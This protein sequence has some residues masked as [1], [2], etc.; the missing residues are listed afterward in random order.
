M[1]ASLTSTS[2]S[3]THITLFALARVRGLSIGAIGAGSVVAI[4]F[5]EGAFIDRYRSARF[6][7]SREARFANAFVHQT[8]IGISWRFV[9]T[10]GTLA[11][12]ILEVGIM[13]GIAVTGSQ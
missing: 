11:A 2:S 13:I 9:R 8:G 3:T 4:V 7:V 5:A 6:S 12:D 1:T 10:S